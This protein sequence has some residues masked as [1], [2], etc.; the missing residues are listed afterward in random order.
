MVVVLPQGAVGEW[1]VCYL[2]SYREAIEQGHTADYQEVARGDRRMPNARL[3]VTASIA[4]FALGIGASGSASATTTGWMVGGT[5]LAGSAALATTAAVDE[6]YKISGG[7]VEIECTGT[8]VNGITPEI[9][10]SI[11]GS[12]SS[13]IFTGCKTVT[14]NCTL[15]ATEI[16]TVPITVEATLEGALGA[17]AVFTPKSGTLIDTFKFNGESCGVSGLKSVTGKAIASFPV[18]QDEHTLQLSSVNKSATEATLKLGSSAA[19]LSGSA[20]I[21]LASGLTWSFL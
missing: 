3:L 16:A 8:A 6:R 9:G 4:V 14:K 7:G 1:A 19:T 21:K 13:I 17:A 2:R 18:G 10:E 11:K 15:A 12:V 5:K 20:L